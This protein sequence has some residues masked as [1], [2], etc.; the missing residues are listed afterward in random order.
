M[1][2]QQVVIRFFGQ[3]DRHLI[4]KEIVLRGFLLKHLT[5][6]GLTAKLRDR[7]LGGLDIGDADHVDYE[8]MVEISL[9]N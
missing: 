2:T 3:K 1:E 8:N 7:R 6:L 9:W 4:L 5:Q